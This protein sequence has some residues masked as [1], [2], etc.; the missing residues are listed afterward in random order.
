[1]AYQVFAKAQAQ[2]RTVANTA[3]TT[4][5]TPPR[6]PPSLLAKQPPLHPAPLVLPQ[7]A[8]SSY[9]NTHKPPSIGDPTFSPE[10][11]SEPLTSYQTPHPH[12]TV[13]PVRTAHIPSLSRITGLLLPIRYPS[14]FYTACITDPVIASLSRVAVYHDHPVPSGPST[15]TTFGGAHQSTT[16]TTGGGL[17]G[18][19][20]VIGG[21]RCRLER[22]FPEFSG[23]NGQD[24]RPPPTNLYIQTLHLLSPHRG[25]GV[26]ASL[27]NALLFAKPPSRGSKAYRVSPLVRHYNIHTVTAHVHETNDEGL[28]WYVARGFHVEDGVVK[29][30][31]R[32]LNPGG[33]RIVRLDLD[34]DNDEQDE[35]ANTLQQDSEQSLQSSD[36]SKATKSANEEQS[37]DDDDWEKLEAEED[38]DHGVV[39][40]TDSQL[41]D[42][43]SPTSTAS[44]GKRKR[45][46][47]QFQKRHR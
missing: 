25:N 1:M 43:N 22:L 19:D 18:T 32:R 34:W 45:D 21:I 37:D 33:A 29:G 20:K 31:Y 27:L 7:S 38:D 24:S 42:D 47:E 41:L 16:S 5:T 11:F 39:H 30:Y 12:V 44:S 14:S 46:L 9:S 35:E 8:S 36:V 4:A 40:L 2:Q 10:S 23:L 13:D 3:S 15:E 28:R 26:A 17:G 6:S